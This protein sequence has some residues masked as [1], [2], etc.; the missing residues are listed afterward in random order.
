MQ[1]S[2]H[3]MLRGFRS[4][5]FG[6]GRQ[7]FDDLSTISEGAAMR[8]GDPEDQCV[9]HKRSVREPGAR[10]FGTDSQNSQSSLPSGEVVK[11]HDSMDAAAMHPI[12]KTQTVHTTVL[13]DDVHQTNENNVFMEASDSDDEGDSIEAVFSKTRH[14]RAVAVREALVRGFDAHSRDENGNTLLHICAQN[15]LKKLAAVVIS[16]GCPVNAFNRRGLT[17]LDYCVSYQFN[18]MASWLK[19]EHGAVCRAPEVIRRKSITS[20]R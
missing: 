5:F 20:L 19:E 10:R 3:N 8:H 4:S 16:A 6:E 13:Q 17:P 2:S 15:N 18:V 12:L 11:K 9:P 7:Q 14:N 1:E